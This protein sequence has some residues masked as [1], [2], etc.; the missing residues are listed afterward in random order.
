MALCGCLPCGLPCLPRLEDVSSGCCQ[1]Q[2]LDVSTDSMHAAGAAAGSSLAQGLAALAGAP[3]RHS[4]R[5]VKIDLYGGSITPQLLPTPAQVA[6]LLLPGALPQL[7]ELQLP[8]TVRAGSLLQGGSGAG[9]ARLR[10]PHEAPPGGPEQ[11]LQLLVG[12]L[13]DA[14]VQGLGRFLLMGGVHVG[15]QWSTAANARWALYEGCA[16]HCQ[17][18]GRLWMVL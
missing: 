6:P 4:L 3:C 16:A 13:E 5:S 1:L 8:I 12:G 11:H 14:G 7:Q 18:S 15:S 10:A 2:E 17:L 9:R